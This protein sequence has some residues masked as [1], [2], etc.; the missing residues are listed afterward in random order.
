MYPSLSHDPRRAEFIAQVV[1]DLSE[2]GSKYRSELDQ[3]VLNLDFPKAIYQELGKLGYLGPL[4]PTEYGG[5]GW[6]VAE[7]IILSEEI[8]RHGLVQGQVAAQGQK[9]LLDWGTEEQKQKWLGPIAKGEKVFAES[10][11]EPNMGS[12]FKNMSATAK[13][14]GSDWILNGHKTHI[15]MGFDCDVT[16]FYA[17]A[18]EGITSFLVET[19]LPGITRELTDPIGLRM[20]RTADVIFENVRV[21]N[22]A[23]LGHAGGGMDTFLSTFNISRLG[24]A[25]ELIG[26]GRRALEI[27]IN[28][29]ES[30][31]VGT[32]QVTDFQG[33]QWMIAEA[34]TSLQTAAL[35]RDYAVITYERGEDVALATSV[36]KRL[37]ISAAETAIDTAFS[38]MGGKALYSDSELLS[39][40]ND[41]RVLKVAGGSQE[42]LRNFIARR[43]L[44]DPLH[45]GLA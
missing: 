7:Y 10:I 32:N 40:S 30:R 1:K 3:A 20:I 25:S 29:G 39:I 28:Y 12:S 43:V 5:S 13:R 23:L 36:A 27:A 22:S 24:N 21:P 31:T 41:I 37:S 17:I 34:W 9:W 26:L 38:V 35:A 19:N 2:L 42:V 11:S 6:N 15:N 45:E 33:I 16:L 14:D 8:G 18:D 44:K 4:I